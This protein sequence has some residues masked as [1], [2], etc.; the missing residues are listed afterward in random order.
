MSEQD[1]VSL[2]WLLGKEGEEGGTQPALNVQGLRYFGSFC[3]FNPKDTNQAVV[4]TK[5]LGYSTLN[6]EPCI[7]SDTGIF[8]MS[9][10]GAILSFSLVIND[11]LNRY[12]NKDVQNY[13][14]SCLGYSY[15]IV[16]YFHD[17]REK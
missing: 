6:L 9:I 14:R 16:T 11:D 2:V 8:K 13:T 1:T 3:V 17:Y 4:A 10:N 7:V 12:R 15:I 5:T